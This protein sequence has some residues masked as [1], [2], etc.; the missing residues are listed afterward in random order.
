MQERKPQAAET[1]GIVSMNHPFANTTQDSNL[2]RSVVD[3]P[4]RRH[5]LTRY[6]K[7][8]STT[9]TTTDV[10]SGKY[11][12][13][14]FPRYKKSPGS[15]PKGRFNRPT[16][17]TT[18]PTATSSA[19]RKISHLPSSITDSPRQTACFVLQTL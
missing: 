13:V 11:T 12:V 19:P 14:F 7:I 15:C 3:E 8:D 5:R 16:T 9:L 17:I 2:D 4:Y 10:A 6:S 18:T 1:P